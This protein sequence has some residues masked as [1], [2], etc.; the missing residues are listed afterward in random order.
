MNKRLI[1]RIL[2]TL[3]LVFVNSVSYA[4]T[5]SFDQLATSADLTTA[6]YNDDLDDVY[7]K[8]NS[9]IQTD[10]IENDTITEAD[11]A[12]AANPRVRD[13]EIFGEFVDDGLLQTTTSGTLSG[14]IP[15]GTAYPRGYRVD[16]ASGTARTYTANR[17]TFADLDINGD[18]QYSEVVIDG[19][20]PAIAT[21]SIRLFR[22]STDATEVTNVQ[23]LRILN[24]TSGFR[25]QV[26]GTSE[27]TLEDLLIT[28]SPI[29]GGK[30][31]GWIQGCQVSWDTHTTFIVRRG[32]IWVNGHFRNI[33]TDISV[34]QTADGPSAGTSGL[35][36]GAIA[37]STS[38]DIYAVADQDGQKTFSISY[39]T[40]A[41]APSG[42]TNYRKIGNIKTDASSLF[43]SRDISAHHSFVPQEQI[44]AWAVVDLSTT[45]AS[46][47]NYRNVSGLIDV[48]V[49]D[50]K[51]VWNFNFNN[52][53]Y[54]AVGA[55]GAAG[56]MLS[57]TNTTDKLVGSCRF[58]CNEHGGTAQ[59]D[60]YVGVIVIGDKAP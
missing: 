45:P 57:V 30:T 43:T 55:G 15:A 4:A 25:N 13:Y 6:V 54:S 8:V 42:T 32:S 44:A 37:A 21:N 17:W 47:V 38:Y 24:P 18:F 51:L 2:L 39:S 9:A 35:D 60:P 49:G 53:L 46:L 59:D 27:S 40:S 28:G 48:G 26:D 22:A 33:S 14:T 7:V 11:F 56:R 19:A 31:V 23:D 52:A 29:R 1:T 36:T 3:G 41:S 50:F 58:S 12:D 34:P 10:N 16:K 5:I 20:T